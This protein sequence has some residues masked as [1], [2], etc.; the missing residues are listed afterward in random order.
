MVLGVEE[1]EGRHQQQDRRGRTE[2]RLVVDV[3][4]PLRVLGARRV[5]CGHSLRL[6]AAGDRDQA[7]RLD[8]VAAGRDA[9]R[10]DAVEHGV[11]LRERSLHLREGRR[12]IALL[13]FGQRRRDLGFAAPHQPGRERRA[14]AGRRVCL[15]GRVLQLRE[16]ELQLR[17]LQ[18]GALALALT[19]VAGR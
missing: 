3:V 2:D 15:V 13:Q 18:L 17:Q 14:A 4:H 11:E 10:V 16:R 6:C 19:L 12:W 5:E 1:R 7:A 9:D 8:V